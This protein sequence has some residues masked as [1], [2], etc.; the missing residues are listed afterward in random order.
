VVEVTMAEQSDDRVEADSGATRFRRLA[1]E[2]PSTIEGSH[3]GHA[4]FRVTVGKS[5]RIFATLA[6]Q[7]QGFGMVNLTPVQQQHFTKDLPNI[8]EPVPGG[9]GLNGSTLISLDA[10]EATM[11][12]ALRTA[13]EN[14]VRKLAIKKK[15][16]S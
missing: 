7:E 2:L 4:D 13:H 16:K 10:D 5:M 15:A 1:L 14:I 9:W 8:F 3:M 12:G 11:R 6:A